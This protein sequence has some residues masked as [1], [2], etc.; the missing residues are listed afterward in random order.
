MRVLYDELF[1]PRCGGAIKFIVPSNNIKCL[2]ERCLG[3]WGDLKGLNRERTARSLAKT[4][5]APIP[6]DYLTSEDEGSLAWALHELE[7]L[8]ALMTLDQVRVALCVAIDGR[9]ADILSGA[10]QADKG[11]AQITA[12]EGMRRWVQEIMKE[13]GGSE[14]DNGSL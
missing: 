7:S 4:A 6:K 12:L 2:S 1:C 10:M 5:A 9:Y 14:K 8:T 3:Y 11:E 13:Y